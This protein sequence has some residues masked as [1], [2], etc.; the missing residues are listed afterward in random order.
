MVYWFF[1]NIKLQTPLKVCWRCHATK[2]TSDVAF[3]YTN[4]ADDAPWKMTEFATEPWSEM[5]AYALL[6]GFSLRMVGIDILHAFHLGIGRDLIGSV[7][8]EMA[9]DRFWR[10]SNLDK[11]L[12]AAS[13]ELRQYAK[14]KKLSLC[15]KR[16]SKSN[17]NWLSDAYP[18]AHV[19]GYDT[20]VILK[21]LDET[22]QSGNGRAQMS[23]DLKTLVWTSN[24]ILSVWSNSSMLQQHHIQIVGAVFIRTYIKMASECIQR[25]VRLYRIRPKFH[26]FHHLV[27]ENRPSGFNPHWFSTWMDE[28]NIKRIMRIKRMTHKLQA[29]DRCIKRWLL[30]LRPKLDALGWEKKRKAWHC[31]C[32][33]FS[34][35]ISWAH[36]CIYIYVCFFYLYIFIY[37]YI[38]SFL[39]W[40]HGFAT[41]LLHSCRAKNLWP[42]YIFFT[43]LK[44]DP[45]VLPV[46]IR[47]FLQ[48]CHLCYIGLKSD[49]MRHVPDKPVQMYL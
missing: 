8:R 10:G 43:F 31:I 46:K 15:I 27:M 40:C 3:S 26:L 45:R 22:L 34:W 35:N 14:S 2:G 42:K 33:F 7:I 11:Q 37:I 1:Q 39:F 17:L 20:F 4:V 30:G 36:A 29:T 41:L 28:D 16:F 23:D 32:D 9:R 25:R 6:P 38:C 5:P 18:Q 24:S 47:E 19:K 44:Q 48:F 13:H 21:W 12:E 49:R